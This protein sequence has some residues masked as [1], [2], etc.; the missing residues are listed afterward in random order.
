[1]LQGGHDVS[2]WLPV[3]G[4]YSDVVLLHNAIVKLS[5][6]FELH[7]MKSL[8]FGWTNSNY[9]SF[10]IS[11]IHSKTWIVAVEITVWWVWVGEACRAQ[12]TLDGKQIQSVAVEAPNERVLSNAGACFD[13]K[14]SITTWGNCKN[15]QE[16]SMHDSD[17]SFDTSFPCL[18]NWR[19]RNVVW[20]E[21]QPPFILQQNLTSFIPNANK[22]TTVMDITETKID[23]LA[24]L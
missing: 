9:S 12:T 8:I 3:N 21:V 24:T 18:R 19:W 5:V 2:L 15:V 22:R 13:I 20:R 1:M 17:S 6:T 11:G 4:F 10:Y 16:S 7:F 14:S 23:Y